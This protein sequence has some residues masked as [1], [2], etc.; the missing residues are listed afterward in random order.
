MVRIYLPGR[1][2]LRGTLSPRFAEL[3]DLEVLDLGYTEVS[4]DVAVLGNLS[5]L[6]QLDL[7]DTKVFVDLAALKNLTK[8]KRLGLSYTNAIGDLAA[9]KNLRGLEELYLHKTHVTGNLS[10]LKNL[11]ELKNLDLVMSNVIGEIA[12]LQNLK[13]LKRLS[14]GNTQVSGDIAALKNLR[15]LEKLNLRHTNVAGDIAALQNLRELQWLCLQNTNVIGDMS[16]LRATSLGDNFYIG[17]T[18]IT[19]PQDAALKEVLLTLGLAELKLEG[20]HNLE[21]VVWRLFCR[22]ANFFESFL[23]WFFWGSCSAQL[24]GRNQYSPRPPREGCKVVE[25]DLPRRWHRELRGTLSPRFA[26]LPDLRVLDL[27]HTRVSGDVAVL[28]NLRKL[29]ELNLRNTNVIGDIGA[30]AN[31]TSLR[32]KN[33][34]IEGTKITCEDATLRAVLLKLGLEATL[35]TDLMNFKGVKRMLSCRNTKVFLFLHT[36]WRIKVDHAWPE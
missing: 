8:L 28:G 25:I 14:V 12:A 36:I 7:R 29:E 3:P 31:A 18:K 24:L 11:R 21:G 30:L 17:D 23:P 2:E 19:C 26:E 32:Q 33:F 27:G 35:L 22:V 13:K 20:L 34:R 15:K 10:A 16:A 4:G 6:G 9:L 5:E 1:R